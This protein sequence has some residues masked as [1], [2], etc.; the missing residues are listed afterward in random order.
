MKHITKNIF[1]DTNIIEGNNF[2]H[3]SYIQSLL[4]YSRSG[5]IKLFMTSISKM[6]LIDRMQKRLIETK[7]EHNRLVKSLNKH[8]PRI[9]KN[10]RQYEELE[11]SPIKIES[12]LRELVDKLNYNIESA[13][14][15]VINSNNVN[16]EEVFSLFYQCKPPFSSNEKKRYEFPDAFILKSVDNWCKM[17]KKRMLFL[18]KDNDFNGYKSRNLLFRNDVKILLADI[19]EYYDSIQENQIIPFVKE[20]L[21]TNE[22]ELNELINDQL[23]N[24]ITIDID[25]ERMGNLELLGRIISKDI[26]S[27]RKDYAEISCIIEL[28][29]GFT[30]FPSTHDVNRM[31]FEDN[32]RPKKVRD[33]I[34]IPCDLEINLNKENDIKLKWINSNQKIR[35]DLN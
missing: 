10:L 27:I 7:E 6:E 11:V 21:R 22:N 33:K 2:F 13:D 17:N 32:L 31:L 34:E 8:K 4:H 16:I 29:Y 25:Y 28:K 15:E 3:G 35:I 9:L 1:L 5:V 18:T 19:S 24:L 14:I 12:S 26:T 23:T 30:V 20:Q